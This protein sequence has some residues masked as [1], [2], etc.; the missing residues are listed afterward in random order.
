MSAGE[1]RQKISLVETALHDAGPENAINAV[2]DALREIARSVES[3]E[4][5]AKN[6]DSSSPPAIPIVPEQSERK[7]R[8]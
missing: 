2:V 6:D 4:K 5:P 1:I 7:S 8:D 3:L